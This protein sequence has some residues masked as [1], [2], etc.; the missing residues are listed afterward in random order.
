MSQRESY[1]LLAK[2]GSIIFVLP[3]CCLAGFW[4]GDWLDGWLGTSPV[5]AIVLLLV[6]AAAGFWEIFRLLGSE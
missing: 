6:G 5:L 1:R 3:A 2:Y 4:I